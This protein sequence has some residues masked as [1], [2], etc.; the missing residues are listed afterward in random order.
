MSSDGRVTFS[1]IHKDVF[2]Q[3]LL[4]WYIFQFLAWRMKI[5]ELLHRVM[6]MIKCIVCKHNLYPFMC[7]LLLVCNDEKPCGIFSSKHVTYYMLCTSGQFQQMLNNFTSF[8]FCMLIF[9]LNSESFLASKDGSKFWWLLWFLAQNN[10]W[11]NIFN[12]V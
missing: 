2:W 1:A 7:Y 6:L 4:Y 10:P 8:E 3:N 11:V 5:K 9:F 12:T